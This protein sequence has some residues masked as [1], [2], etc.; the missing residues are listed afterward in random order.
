MKKHLK[1]FFKIAIIICLIAS[2]FGCASKSGDVQNENLPISM[3]SAIVF[4]TLE[5]GMNYYVGNNTNPKNRIQLRLVVKA[6]SIMEDEDQL[7]VAHL[8]EHMA[9]NGSE[10]FSKNEV[11]EFFESTGMAFGHSLNAY[12]S[13]EQTVY[14]LE[15]PADNPEFLEKAMLI[16]KDWASGLTFDQEE[17]DKE[18]GVIT[19]EWRLSNENLIG[20]LSQAEFPLIFG[21][22]IF[23]KR[24]PIGK[25]EIIQNIPRERVVD[26]YEKWYRPDLMSVIVVGDISTE[27]VEQAIINTMGEIPAATEPL[28]L[29]DNSCEKNDKSILIFK[30]KEQPY[31]LV[32]LYD[33]SKKFPLKTIQDYKTQLINEFV[34]NILYFR[35][36]DIVQ[37]GTSPFIDAAVSSG[38]IINSQYLNSL[39]FVST[40]DQ[41]ENGLK[42]ILDEVDKLKT[43]GV[44][45]SEVERIK[46]MKLA[47]KKSESDY[48]TSYM[49]NALTEYC[50]GGTTPISVFTENQI[51]EKVATSIT[52]EEVTEAARNVIENRGF[53]LEVLA[54]ENSIIPEEDVL[55][56]IWT[57]YSNSEITANEEGEILNDWI[58]VP[59]KPGKITSKKVVSKEDNIT[60]YVLSNG[61]RVLAKKTDY[62]KDKVAFSFISEGGLSLVED[63]D[64]PSGVF[65]ANYAQISGLNGTSYM[66]IQKSIAGKDVNYSYQIADYYEGIFGE[67]KSSDLETLFQLTYLTFEKPYFTDEMWNYLYSNV[68]TMAKSAETQ[69]TSIFTN[70]LL[71][72]IYGDN[73]RKQSL[74]PEF[75]E[76]L[77][78]DAAAKIFEDRFSNAMD[79]TF[80]F[81]GDYEEK[82]L[83]TLLE[84]YIATIPSFDKTEK[85]I[86][87]ES[88]FP[89]DIQNVVIEKGIGNQSQVCLGFGG[90]LPEFSSEEERIQNDL[91][92]SFIYLLDIKLRESIREDK[93]GSYGVSVYNMTNSYPKSNYYIE[94][95]FGCEPGR[96]DELVEEM[97]NQ[98]KLL[99]TELV[100]D[101]YIAKLVENYKRNME[102]ETLKDNN[103]WTSR[104]GYCV[105]NNLPFEIITDATTVPPLLTAETMK[106]L[107]NQYLD[108]DNYVL[109]ILEPETVTK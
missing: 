11:I 101:S 56:D 90:D 99:Q 84:T 76:K 62:T 13:F 88:V 30:D 83:E 106:N 34:F 60:E 77:N 55:M 39:I 21:D 65:A 70:A 57:N 72:A 102:P 95:S 4:G 18:R 107:A 79:F 67:A 7:G 75:V 1:S 28:E 46:Q 20:R 104:I 93:G 109:G 41:I 26:F 53:Y 50:I 15:I 52:V 2:L 92:D 14:M 35:I 78:K 98:I 103:R 24:L 81:V 33:T 63:K 91:L 49:V 68:S 10:N 94:I 89:S 82:D 27:E 51:L 73:I 108:L 71:E 58:I 6:G 25:A 36:Q 17:L 8:V 42:L 9:F 47:S 19:E 29:P 54:N 16:L 85:S 38:Q 61:A 44:S 32:G 40:D 3:D 96:E 64:Y 37:S 43:F 45:S 87:K 74:T 80:I 66:D 48:T 12:T 69:P 23:A 100:D 59:E 97:F 105:M 5:N 31:T 22:S 86:W